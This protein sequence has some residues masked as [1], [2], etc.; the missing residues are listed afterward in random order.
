MR[1][2][3][4]LR[5]L[6]LY[7]LRKLTSSTFI[8]FEWLKRIEPNIN[9]SI[10]GRSQK[11]FQGR[12]RRYFAYPFLVADDAMQMYFYKTLYL[13]LSTPLVCASSTSILKQIWNIFYTFIWN[14]FYTSAI[15]NAI[16]F[17]N[18]P[19]SIFEHCLQTSR[20]LRII[21]GPKNMGGKKNN[22]VKHSCKTVSSMGAIWWRIRGTCPPTFLE[23]GGT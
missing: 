15:R 21:N 17:I 8:V 22:E 2:F 14:V 11:F 4:L 16:F 7:R 6:D 1:A 10:H 12:Q 9:P 20:N 23:R 13:T 19:I 5:L 3:R 18:C